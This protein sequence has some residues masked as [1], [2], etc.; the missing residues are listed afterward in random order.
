MKADRRDSN[1]PEYVALWKS[2][3]YVWIPWKPGMGADGLLVRPGHM[4]VVEIKNPDHAWKLTKS[5]KRLKA[6]LERVGETY[7][8]CDSYE[9]AKYLAGVI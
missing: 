6:E 8:I 2:L 3:G 5:E 7:H 4:Y 1:E 9:Y